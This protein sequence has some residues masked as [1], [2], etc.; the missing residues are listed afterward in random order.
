[1]LKSSLGFYVAFLRSF[2]RTVFPEI[3]EAF[4][5]FVPDSDWSIVEQARVRGRGRVIEMVDSLIAIH[6][7]GRDRGT[8]WARDEIIAALIEPLGIPSASRGIH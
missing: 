4:E 1:G 8:D 5:Q 7:T 3:R 2:S 6:E